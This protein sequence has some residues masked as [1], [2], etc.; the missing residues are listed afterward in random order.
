MILKFS[1]PKILKHFS[2]ISDI[3]YRILVKEYEMEK[4]KIVHGYLREEMNSASLADAKFGRSKLL[5]RSV[6]PIKMSKTKNQT[7]N[8]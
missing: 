7:P 1:C 2:L 4:K 3:F 8:T 6:G 5:G